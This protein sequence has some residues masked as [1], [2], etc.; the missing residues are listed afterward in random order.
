MPCMCKMLC[1]PKESWLVVRGSLTLLSGAG[2]TLSLSPSKNGV[3]HKSEAPE[4]TAESQL[5]SEL[6]VQ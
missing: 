5:M 4:W 1:F 6:L 2:S 3:S